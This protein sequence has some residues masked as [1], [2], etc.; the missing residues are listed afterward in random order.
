MTVD[1][2]KAYCNQ[3]FTKDTKEATHLFMDGGKLCVPSHHYPTFLQ[4]YAQYLNTGHNISLVEKLGPQCKM[5][6]FLDVDKIGTHDC[7]NIIRV[8]NE[9]IG[10]EGKIYVCTARKGLHIVYNSVVMCDEAQ[11]LINI[12]KS[13]LSTE[14][15]KHIDSSV[16]KTGLRM[17]G[18]RKYSW[19]EKKFGDR[20]YVP[21]NFVGTYSVDVLKHSVVRIESIPQTA[22]FCKPCAAN[23]TS[24]LGKYLG[25]IDDHYTRV[26]ITKCTLFKN[27]ICVYVQS[28]YCTNLKKCHR[29]N[30][31]YFVI[32]TKTRK[33]YQKCFCTCSNVIGRHYGLCKNYKSKEVT[34]PVEVVQNLSYALSCP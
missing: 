33:L 23:D 6:F 3:W 31:I 26:R 28:K 9:V 22:N 30:N 8:A 14:E 19:A 12:I 10:S 18:S 20:V 13:R 5:R 7:T 34:I 15:S 24:P 32:D 21:E 29:S 1:T 16:Y 27:C 25:K 11:E 2:F 4:A 17:V